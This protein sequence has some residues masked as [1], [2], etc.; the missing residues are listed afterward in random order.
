MRATKNRYKFFG[1]GFD[2]PQ[3]KNLFKRFDYYRINRNGFALVREHTHPNVRLTVNRNCFG[4]R[5]WIDHRFMTGAR[6]KTI[7]MRFS[8]SHIPM[9]KVFLYKPRFTRIA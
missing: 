1:R 6:N 5:N 7:N 8:L 4:M 3:R 9:N 2:H